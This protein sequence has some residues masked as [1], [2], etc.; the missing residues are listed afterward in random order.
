MGF[1]SDFVKRGKEQDYAYDG[2]VYRFGNYIGNYYYKTTAISEAQAL[3]NISYKIKK[4]MNLVP[5]SKIELDKKYL[6]RI[7]EWK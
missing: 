2:P 7:K 6:K 5:N 3:N 1:Y 4:D